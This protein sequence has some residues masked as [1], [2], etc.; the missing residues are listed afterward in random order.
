MPAVGDP[1]H[2]RWCNSG[3]PES[4]DPALATTTTS[5]KLVYA[6]FDGLTTHDKNG[7]PQPSLATSWDISD[8]LRRFTFHL[9]DDARWSN[10]RAIDAYDVAFQVL[11]VLHPSFASPN[12][13]GIEP[14]KNALAFVGG[15]MRVMQR[16]VG[17][18]RAGTIVEVATVGGT[19][20]AELPADRP[21]PS[22]NKRPAR[23]PLA[24]RDLGA[25]A[26]AAYAHV[27]VGGT[28][29]ILELTGRPSS[30]PSP[31]GQAWAY[32]HLNRGDGL[33]GWVLA[34]ELG[35]PPAA[36]L[37]VRAVEPKRVP[38][39]DL[40]SPPPAV[41]EA[42]VIEIDAGDALSLLESVG[43][44]VPDAHTFV[45]ETSDPTPFLISLT[46]GRTLRPTPRE[47]VS[48][49]PR[50]WIVPG[51]TV[52]SGPMTLVAWKERDYVELAR[53]PSY[54]NQAVAKLERLTAFSMNDQSASANYY[55][56]GGCDAVTGNN[57]PSSYFPMINGERTGTAYRDYTPA[58][59][60]GIYF[61]YVNTKKV[62]NVHLRRALAHAIDRTVLPK[63]L[64]GGQIPT[65]Q[66]SPGTPIA[67]LSDEDLAL[68]GVS[69]DTPG[70]AMI[71]QTGVLCYVPPPGL[72]YDPAKAK[73]E[74][75]LARTELGGT[76]PSMTYRYNTGVEG[77]KLIAE[78][79]QDAWK[80]ELGLDVGL[81]SQ[82]WKTFVADTRAG[83]YELARFG[84]IGNFP[85]TEAEF[86]IN[87]RCA[88]P[89]N[90]AQWCDPAFE[91]AMEDAKPLRDRAARLAKIR[92]AE[93]IMLQAAP[94]IPLYIYT[95]HHLQR[96]YVRDLYI[97]LP[98]QVPLY[99]AYLDPAW[100]A[101]GA[102]R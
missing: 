18:L 95:Q 44:R 46:P 59:Y 102:D 52:T 24:L 69:R 81:E 56:A 42:P 67:K 96:P 21:I 29:E 36:T 94:V 53:S 70:V 68:C 2:L 73:A 13:D 77:H 41:V 30:P 15:R 75:A 54:W 51:Q 26:S 14:V 22:S 19:P 79:L 98:D 71:M 49:A 61:A 35:P 64:H 65:A 27:D 86:L 91:Q 16:D 50:R 20:V 10:G 99:E 76:L 47:A 55:F 43:V 28:V 1:R 80:R 39:L 45:L 7:L 88:S 5:L 33:Y 23:A 40:P 32:V 100:Q 66:F 92:E 60:L 87:F 3:E 34:D 93:G 63:I 11:R 85:D 89:D 97:N 78:Y 12:G 6:L 101:G 17:P 72:D 8:D 74:L 9:R 48:R 84:S 90:R 62:D 38:G 82:E 4:L 57:I 58:P 31:D 25:P 37:G 83:N